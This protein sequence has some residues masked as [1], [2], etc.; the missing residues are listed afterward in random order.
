MIDFTS[1]LTLRTSASNQLQ[2]VVKE[3]KSSSTKVE[4]TIS[5]YA[6]IEIVVVITNRSLKDLDIQ[7]GSQLYVLLKSSWIS[8]YKTLPTELKEKNRLQGLLSNIE[9]D[10][11]NCEVTIDLSEQN[12]LISSL[13][14]SEFQSL[15]L[16]KNDTLWAVFDTS[17][18]LLAV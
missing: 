15:N 1:K 9:Q 8:L 17:S 13:S 10:E 3:I 18:A 2:G 4:V 11:E 14:N 5:L 12:T 16:K 6:D 7:E